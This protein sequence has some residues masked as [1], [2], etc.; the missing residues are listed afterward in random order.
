MDAFLPRACR[1]LL[2][3]VA[4]SLPWELYQRTPVAGLTLTKLAGV[5]VIL[6]AG[7]HWARHGHGRFPRTGLEGPIAL[8]LL[9]GV[10]SASYSLDRASTLFHLR[11]YVSYAVFFYALVY[12]LKSPAA[13]VRLAWAYVVSSAAVAGLTVLCAAGW[14]RPTLWGTASWAQQRLIEEWRDGLPMRMVGASGD[15][16]FAAM[17]LL[18]AFGASLFLVRRKKRGLPIRL[19]LAGLRLALLAGILLT[20]SRSGLVVAGLL[21]VSWAAREVYRRGLKWASV[22]AAALV[23]AALIY[24]GDDFVE[25]LADRAG[26]GITRDDGSIRGRLRV[27]EVGLALLPEY[28]LLG[29]GLGATD[30]AMARSPYAEEAVMTLHS[31][32]FKV[33]LELGVA[34]FAAYVW[35]LIALARAAATPMV[36]A[37]PGEARR[38]KTAFLAMAGVCFLMTAVQPFALS[39]LYPFVLGLG[40]GPA[41]SR[42]R[43]GENLQ[44]AEAVEPLGWGPLMAAGVALAVV[45]IPNVVAF[46]RSTVRVE[47]FGDA[48]AEALE[49]ERMLDWQ[50]AARAGAVAGWL[51]DPGAGV[52]SGVGPGARLAYPDQKLPSV[53]Y[54]EFAEA[55]VDLKPLYVGLGIPFDDP[56]PA[57][58]AAYAQGRALM[59]ARRLDEAASAYARAWDAESRLG[60]LAFDLAEAFWTARRY[61][62]SLELYEKAGDAAG[63]G[64][65][66]MHG[67]R[68]EQLEARLEALASAGGEAA[69][70]E[71]AAIQR[72]LGRW[73]EAVAGYARVL[74]RFHGCGDAL[75]HLGLAAELAGRRDE[76]LGFYARCLEAQ[77]E[78]YEAG[79]ARTILAEAPDAGRTAGVEARVDP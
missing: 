53:P 13:S 68:V 74:E 71:A 44:D 8:F 36:R 42:K 12:L 25:I 41:V 24:V 30:A 32:P 14:L 10:A 59:A 15:F 55:V 76:A 62:R 28:G 39:S 22:P 16:N 37:G 63:D 69:A 47:R 52:I 23:L 29:C 34:G 2:A 60:Y 73:E 66:G 7:I 46:Q 40:L 19:G 21:F 61:G 27:Y 79:L 35:F 48:L 51:A 54:F 38:L 20:M 58:A 77:P 11:I 50:R 64:R 17:T 9:M 18:V 43:S 49:A 78:H 33:L 57:G 5:L 56:A 72:R 75:F 3:V 45:V 65:G 26:G 4:V 70:L 31:I 67:R 1:A 6:G